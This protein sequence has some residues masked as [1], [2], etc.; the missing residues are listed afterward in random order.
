[1]TV[2]EE[3]SHQNS[4]VSN[5]LRGKMSFHHWDCCAIKELGRERGFHA[6]QKINF[7]DWGKW[8]VLN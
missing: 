6:G 2:V 5:T 4:H 1:M 8:D 7:N 3:R